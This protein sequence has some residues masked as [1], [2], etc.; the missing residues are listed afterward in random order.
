VKEPAR[1]DQLAQRVATKRLPVRRTRVL[2]QKEVKRT[3][4]TRGRKPLPPLVLAL[5]TSA[6]PLRDSNTGELVF[7][8]E[9]VKTLT[10]EQREL[11]VERLESLVKLLARIRR[12]LA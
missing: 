7:T 1:V 3:K 8:R 9:D 11:A 4:E 6:R 5:R 12:L 10:E 2:V